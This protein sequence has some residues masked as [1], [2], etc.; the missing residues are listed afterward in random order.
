[1]EFFEPD[2]HRFPCLKLCIEAGEI[3][4]TAPAVVNAANEIAVDLFLREKIGFTEIS[5]IVAQALRNHKPQKADSVEI[6]EQADRETR[7]K[8][9]AQYK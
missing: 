7:Q 5:E 9:A 3:G 6:I 4:G 1:M 2:F 8:I